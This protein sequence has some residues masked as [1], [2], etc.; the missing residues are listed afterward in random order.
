MGS[1]SRGGLPRG[2][3]PNPRSEYWAVGQTPLR[4]VNRMAHRC[5]NITLPQT[6]FVGGK[7][8]LYLVVYLCHVVHCRPVTG[9]FVSFYREEM[10]GLIICEFEV[11]GESVHPKNGKRSFLYIH[12]SHFS[13]GCKTEGENGISRLISETA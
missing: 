3:C 7:Y 6:S 10:L 8:A 11:Y 4:P 9:R 5:K 12:M 1:V 2:I 13:Y